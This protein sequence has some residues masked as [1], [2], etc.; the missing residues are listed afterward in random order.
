MSIEDQARA[1]ASHHPQPAPRHAPQPGPIAALQAAADALSANPLIAAITTHHGMGEHLNAQDVDTVMRV[2]ASIEAA[3]IEVP[4]RYQ[5]A[6][7]VADMVTPDA[8]Q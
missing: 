3:R 2:V 8:Q 7:H 5:H 1:A 6:A 4:Q